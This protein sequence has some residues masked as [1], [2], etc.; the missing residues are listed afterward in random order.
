MAKDIGLIESRFTGKKYLVQAEVVESYTSGKST[1]DYSHGVQQWVEG[2]DVSG[3]S[4]LQPDGTTVNV[5][6]TY[7]G[8][9]RFLTPPTPKRWIF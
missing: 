9:L 6:P 2:S 8:T 5:T 4:F 1:I 7:G 3:W